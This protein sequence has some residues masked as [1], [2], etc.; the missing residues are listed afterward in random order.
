MPSGGDTAR[1]VADPSRP[2]LGGRGFGHRHQLLAALEQLLTLC[3]I[4]RR[5]GPGQL[6]DM[7]RGDRATIESVR[8]TRHG[9]E[10]ACPSDRPAG[11]T[12]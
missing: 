2:L 4:E 1:F 12:Q 3:C 9:V 8:E 11:I 7:A 5:P 10:R 6:I